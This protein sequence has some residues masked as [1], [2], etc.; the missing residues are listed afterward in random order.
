MSAV[1]SKILTH[2]L[3]RQE[4]STAAFI[5]NDAEGCYDGMVNNLILLELH[6]MGMPETAVKALGD[7][8]ATIKTKF[9]LS[10]TTY[11]NSSDYPLYGPGQ[12]STLG[13]FI[14]LILFI[15][16]VKSIDPQTPRTTFTS[17]TGE[18]TISDIGEGFV[19][20]VEAGC[21]ATH[22]YDISMSSQENRAI[23]VVEAQR[24]LGILVQ[25]W[26]RFLFAG[27]QF[28]FK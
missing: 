1:L 10:N 25:V 21:T 3:V 28:N 12:G 14:W 4:K 11:S 9:G 5:E 18:V 8:W 26:E 7:T 16:L 2:D 23:A 22:Q 15:L 6:R 13:P 17:V 20:D 27:R 24:K 19:D